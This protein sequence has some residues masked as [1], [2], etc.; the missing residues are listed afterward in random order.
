MA[1]ADGEDGRVL[2]YGARSFHPG[3][4]VRHAVAQISGNKKSGMNGKVY[5]GRGR[6]D[7]N[8]IMLR[9]KIEEKEQ[10]QRKSIRIEME[11]NP[12][13]QNCL[14]RKLIYFLRENYP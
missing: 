2:R 11:G 1:S 14:F 6:D 12:V 10:G 5:R 7:P 8:Q 13:A 4:Y 3:K 9:K